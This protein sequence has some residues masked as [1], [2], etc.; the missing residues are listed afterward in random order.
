MAARRTDVHRLQEVVRLH[1]LGL[2]RRRIARRL[3]MGR[4]TVVRA[5]EAFARSSLLE[6]AP[7][8]LPEAGVLAQAM[9]ETYA[10]A[11]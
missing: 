2:S 1:R 3:R 5:L 4:D 9:E 6:G 7:G 8:D 10:A 11:P